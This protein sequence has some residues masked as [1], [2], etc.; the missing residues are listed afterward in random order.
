MA[1]SWTILKIWQGKI[2]SEARQQKNL[3]RHAGQELPG[4]ERAQVPGEEQKYMQY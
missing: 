3:Q 1:G 4:E 2:A